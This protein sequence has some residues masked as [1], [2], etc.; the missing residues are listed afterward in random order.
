MKT[1]CGFVSWFIFC[2]ILIN[3]GLVFS[4]DDMA[5]TS[6]LQGTTLEAEAQWIWGDVVS[7]DKDA[8][9]IVVQY[10]DYET[11]TEKEMDVIAGDNTVYENINSF[12]EIKPQDTLS[13]DYIIGTDGSIIARNI[14]VEKPEITGISP[15]ETFQEESTA[16]L[17]SE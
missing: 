2:C 14:S 9:K 10:L 17:D 5:D 7:V 12:D 4:Q 1:K 11:D 13:I 16:V 3:A 6:S 15:E 8:R